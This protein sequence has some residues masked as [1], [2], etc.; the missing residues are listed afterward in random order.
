MSAPHYLIVSSDTTLQDRLAKALENGFTCTFA[1]DVKSVRAALEEKK[2][3]ALL[4]NPLEHFPA[5]ENPL[6]LA[7]NRYPKIQAALLASTDKS[8]CYELLRAYGLGAALPPNIG[9][10]A[11]L[12]RVFLKHLAKPESLFALEC[13]LDNQMHF[14]STR[15]RASSDRITIFE[16]IRQ[17]F[18]PHN[19][20]NVHDLQLVFEELLNNAVF[21]AFHNERN[22]PKYSGGKDQPLDLE[23]RVDLEWAS[24]E[25][26]GVL[27]VTDNQGLLERPTIWDRFIRQTSLTGLLDTSGRGIYLTHLLSNLMLI[28]ITPG[29]A[30]RIAIFF[31]PGSARQPKPISVQFSQGE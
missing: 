8:S 17:T 22:A 3:D 16:Q 20:V 21:H 5:D 15:L 27:V 6:R 19:H 26:F 1:P 7:R 12:L 23:D 18:T 9:L 29:K 13:L 25:N 10:P 11:S 28:T 31:C 2:P 14:A 4:L 30:A 24:G